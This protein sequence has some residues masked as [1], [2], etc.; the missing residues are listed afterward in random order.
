MEGAM[1]GRLVGR[2]VPGRTA[3]LNNQCPTPRAT[4]SPTQINTNREC[5]P[6]SSIDLVT[7]QCV[8]VPLKCSIGVSSHNEVPVRQILMLIVIPVDAE[9]LRPLGLV[10][11]QT[12]SL[13][14][15]C[16]TPH[17]TTGPTQ[18]STQCIGVP[19]KCSIGVS[20]HNEVPVRQIL[21]LIVIPGDTESLRPLSLT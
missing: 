7:K 17:A 18:I 5:V 15:Q 20:P 11:G 6:M 1:R 12:A 13:N 14:N 21:M 4:T 10:P 8:G 9:S 16:P 2:M 3:S 19:L